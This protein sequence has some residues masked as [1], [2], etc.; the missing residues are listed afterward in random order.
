MNQYEMDLLPSPNRD[1]ARGFGQFQEQDEFHLG[2]IVWSLDNARRKRP[3][4]RNRVFNNMGDCFIS[5]GLKLKGRE[6]SDS[7]MVIPSAR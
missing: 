1:I 4:I 7:T 3:G 5:M 2:V 6:N